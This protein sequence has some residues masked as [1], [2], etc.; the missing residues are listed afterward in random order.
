MVRIGFGRLVPAS[1]P[2]DPY[3]YWTVLRS[4]DRSSVWSPD[5]SSAKFA[6]RSSDLSVELTF[7]RSEAYASKDACSVHAGFGRFDPSK[8]PGLHAPD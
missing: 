7:D 6:E 1:N 5:W 2:S 4:S 8:I 3:R